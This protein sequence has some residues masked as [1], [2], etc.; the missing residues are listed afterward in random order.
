MPPSTYVALPLR[1]F[2]AERA[3]RRCEYR[4]LQEEL[5]PTTFEVD[6]IIPRALGGPTEPTNLCYACPVCNNAKRSQVM[7]SDPRTRRRTRLFDPRRQHWSDHFDWSDDGGRIV[8]KT[9]A[10]RATI[11]ALEMN[12]PR[13]IHVRLLWTAIGLHP[14]KEA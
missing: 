12:R 5:C 6:H 7:G 14:P 11:E 8:G 3:S 1:R 4:Q 2:V 10:G 13:I 9:I